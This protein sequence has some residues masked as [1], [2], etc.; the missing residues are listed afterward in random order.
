MNT[1][2]NVPKT[3]GERYKDGT[4]VIYASDGKP[5]TVVEAAERRKSIRFHTRLAKRH[6]SSWAHK[7]PVKK[8]SF[9][10]ASE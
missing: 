10:N 5:L 4:E 8:F 6:L 1:K 7:R 2:H 9:A 3:T